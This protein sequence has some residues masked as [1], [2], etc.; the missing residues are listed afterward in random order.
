MRSLHVKRENLTQQF[1]V[2]DGRK[3]KSNTRMT[4]PSYQENQP[5]MIYPHVGDGR[6]VFGLS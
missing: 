2:K 1:D 3:K 6:A 5:E 4:S